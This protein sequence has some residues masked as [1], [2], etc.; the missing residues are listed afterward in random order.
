MK[1][2][3]DASVLFLSSAYF[4]YLERS[5][6]WSYLRQ[7]VVSEQERFDIDNKFFQ[8]KTIFENSW[9]RSNIGLSREIYFQCQNLQKQLHLLAIKYN[10]EK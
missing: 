8:L 1:M 7:S 2:A 9:I 5:W 3:S 4:G 6:F 10:Y